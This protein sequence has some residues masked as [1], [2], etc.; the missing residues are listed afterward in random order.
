VSATLPDGQVGRVKALGHRVVIRI[1]TVLA[2]L[3]AIVGRLA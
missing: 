1:T 3:A 2:S